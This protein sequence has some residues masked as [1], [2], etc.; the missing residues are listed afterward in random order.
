MLWHGALDSRLRE[1]VIMRNWLADRMYY[2]GHSIGGC[3]RLACLPR[4]CSVC[5]LVGT[6]WLRRTRAAVLAATDD[7]V[8][9]GAVSAQTWARASGNSRRFGRADRLVTAIGAWRMIARSCNSLEV[10]LEDGVAAGR[11]RVSR[12]VDRSA[13]VGDDVAV[14]SVR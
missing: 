13:R 12:L 5:G 14:E 7:V 6:R 10:P 4:T 2:D 3:L 11:R 9:D 1:L 8:R